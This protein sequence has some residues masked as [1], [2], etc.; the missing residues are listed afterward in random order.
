MHIPD[1]YLGPATCAA[2]FAAMAPVWA[3]ASHN[4][5]KT[6]KAGQVPLLAVGAAFCFVI[7]MFNIPVPGGTTGHAVGGVLAAVLLGPWAACIA[8]TVALVIQALLFGDGGITAIGANCF[9]MAFV[10]PFAGYAVY[11]LISGKSAVGS[12]RRMAAAGI[13]GYIGLNLAALTTAVLFGIQPMLHH[14]ASGQSLYCPYGLKV[15][16]PMMMGGHILFFGWVEMI[17]T[18][19]AVRFLQ[20][21]EPAILSEAR[22]KLPAMLWIGL[23]VLALLSPLGIYLPAKFAAGAAWGEWGVEELKMHIGFLPQG[24]EKFSALWNAPLPDYAFKGTVG[25]GIVYIVSALLGI[26]LCV[27]VVLIIGRFFTKK[28]GKPRQPLQPRMPQKT[29]GFMER[30]LKGT[31]SLL[32]ETMAADAIAAR[33]GF[34][35]RR[36]P[37]LKIVTLLILLIAV[38]LSKNIFLIAGL[39]CFCLTLAVFSSAGLV[40]FL[41]RTLLFIPL[42]ALVIALPAIFSPITAGE[43]V[44]SIPLLSRHIVITKQ[45]VDTALLFFMRVLASVSFAVLMVLTTRHHALLKALRVFRVPRLFIM[46]LGMCYRYICLLLDIIQDTLTSVKSRV[47]FVSSPKTG[48]RI[49]ALNMA[50]LWLRSYRLH[51]Q[52]YDAMVSRGYTGEPVALNEFRAGRNDYLFLA[53]SLFILIGTLWLNRFFH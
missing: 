53:L 49:A 48:R 8:V 25:S 52:V 9:T 32:R 36:D 39:Y 51:S 42:F 28:S 43:P 18:A 35:Q 38:L 23:A 13:A 37:R 47:G 34:L 1:G 30:T 22:G 10:M 29:D 44:V 33:N 21:L 19:L 45:G 6:L 40:Y 4:V 50:G 15:A 31:V 27:L 17:A 20:K 24:L 12:F 3:L 16:I 7:M 26:A 14:T 5:T 46:V 11:R 41:K 2:G